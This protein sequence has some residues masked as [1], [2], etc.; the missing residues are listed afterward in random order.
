MSRVN[1]FVFIALFSFLFFSSK[2][3]KEAKKSQCKISNF[4]Q[5]SCLQNNSDR[6]LG[7]LNV[8]N[9]SDSDV[10][11]RGY[12]RLFFVYL[13]E[14]KS[15]SKS[16][17]ES[18]NKIAIDLPL[19]HDSRLIIHAN[20]TK[21]VDVNFFVEQ[22]PECNYRYFYA[23][24]FVLIESGLNKYLDLNVKN[25]ISYKGLDKQYFEV[26]SINPL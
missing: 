25:G 12:N 17:V 26:I 4:I 10:V 22:S 16:G 24:G 18:S 11:L 14:A 7:I 23:K 13:T 8:T 19:L 1:L 15:I 3:I 20:T 2:R 6:K 5:I 9:I 21:S